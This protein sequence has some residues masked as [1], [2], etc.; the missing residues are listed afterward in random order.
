M[1]S[2]RYGRFFT[3]VFLI[4]C[5]A[6]GILAGR[7]INSKVLEGR[8]S[9]TRKNIAED[10]LQNGPIQIGSMLSDATLEDL[11]RNTVVLSQAIRDTSVIIFVHPGCDACKLELAHLKSLKLSDEC[12]GKFIWITSYNPRHLEDLRDS[13]DVPVQFLYDHR[14]AW[15]GAYNI[16]DFPF[17]LVIDQE[18]RVLWVVIGGLTEDEIQTVCDNKG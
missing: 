1:A 5:L 2:K 16:R 15:S 17:V 13:I 6:A 14:Q 10:V 9:A 11:D 3:G 4:A 18:L 8:Q 12:Y 7:I